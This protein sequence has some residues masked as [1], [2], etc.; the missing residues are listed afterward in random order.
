MQAVD[1]AL[2]QLGVVEAT[3]NNDGIPAERYNRGDKLPWC[4]AFCLWC[5]AASDDV[6]VAGSVAEF[7]RMRAVSEFEAEMKRRGWWFP[8]DGKRVPV[9][10]DFVFYVGRGASDSGPGRHMGIVERADGN[11][12]H[13]IEGNLGNRVARASHPVRSPKITGY[14]HAP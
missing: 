13:T 7:Y 8:V 1:V 9:R 14:A 2:S 10:N 3:G 4:A 11:M 5:N 6:K 12:I